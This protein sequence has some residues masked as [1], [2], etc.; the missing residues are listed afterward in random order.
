MRLSFYKP[1]KLG[2]CKNTIPVTN[3]TG[4]VKL[5]HNNIMLRIVWK[6]IYE[7]FHKSGKN[8][9]ETSVT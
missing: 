8:E 1:I 2:D 9:H 5:T 3:F 6:T 7:Q 4:N